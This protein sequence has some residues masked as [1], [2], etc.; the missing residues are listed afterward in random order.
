M[1]YY[2]AAK[3]RHSLKPIYH[4]GIIVFI[5]LHALDMLSTGLLVSALGPSIEGNRLC[6]WM[7]ENYGLSTLVL[8]KFSMVWLAIRMYFL[9]RPRS[10]WILWPINVALCLV[11]S[12]N[13]R[14]VAMMIR[15]M[16]MM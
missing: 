14:Y 3:V 4:A 2:P 10:Q 8:F 7:I 6:A 16:R 13:L 11:V 1:L 12:N 5:L 9:L 15:M